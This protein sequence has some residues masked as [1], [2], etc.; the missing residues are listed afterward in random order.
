MFNR[1]WNPYLA[2]ALAGVLMILSVWV[3]GKFFGTSTTFVRAAAVIE[4]SIGIDTSKNLH[5]T[6]KKGKYGAGAL[7][8]WQLMFV[9][10]ILIGSFISAR[11]SGD[12]KIQAVPEIWQQ[13]FGK[14]PAKRGVVAFGGGI[15][16]LFG[17][18]LAG[19]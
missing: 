9:V 3:S 8:D 5:F 16:A 7:P 6:E 19:G 12:F 4:E 1:T 15:I 13:H 11:S 10:G 18:R 17:A 14:N 2:G